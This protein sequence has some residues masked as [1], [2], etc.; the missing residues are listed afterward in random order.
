MSVSAPHPRPRD[1]L[2]T[3][4]CDNRGVVQ[5]LTRAPVSP[6]VSVPTVSVADKPL[7]FVAWGAIAGRSQEIAEALGGSARC[8]F[9]IGSRRPP[10]LVRYFLSSIATGAYLLRRRPKV[11]IVTNPP[12]PAALVTYLWARV[13]GAAFALDSHPGGFG[14]QG[15]RIAARLQW[16]HRFLVRRARFVMVTDESWC[17][18]VRSWGGTPIVVHE[19]PGQWD[20]EPPCRRERLRVLVVGTF[21]SD[22]P[23]AAVVGAATAMPEHDFVLTGDPS[24]CP[25]EAMSALPTNART[26]R[27]LGPRPVPERAG[28][29]RCR[30]HP[31]YGAD[32]G[33][34]GGM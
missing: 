24:L 31:H 32:V 7:A 11:V 34:A 8:F 1:E 14:A 4:S 26:D 33:D 20:L 17:E 22:E 28:C 23:V 15:D 18:K 9:P 21:S 16:I 13:I 29:R 3:A 6:P 19:A 27:L 5:Q 25:T 2:R 30:R 12:V 10:V